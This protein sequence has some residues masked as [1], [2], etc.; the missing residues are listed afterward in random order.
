MNAQLAYELHASLLLSARARARDFAQQSV[1]IYC[2]SAQAEL[3]RDYA[4]DARKDAWSH[5][6]AAKFAKMVADFREHGF[7]MGRQV[8]TACSPVTVIE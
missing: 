7:R 1:S 2:D 3:A 4:A 6:R 5:L 8:Y